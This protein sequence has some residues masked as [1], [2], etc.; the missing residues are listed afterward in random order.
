MIRELKEE[1]G[2]HG[3]IERLIGIYIQKTRR[4]GTILVVG[5]EVA[6][7][8]GTLSLNNELKEARFFGKKD[9]P[10]IPFSS[11]RKIIEKVF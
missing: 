6:I 3:R 7:N 4:Y 10:D 1:T 2:L 9:F 5:Y 11:H 8:K